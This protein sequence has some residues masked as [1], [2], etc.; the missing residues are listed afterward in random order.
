MGKPPVRFR[1]RLFWIAATSVFGLILSFLAY[2]AYLD[3][4][5]V[6]KFEGV[7]WKIP[8]KIYSIPFQLVP[9]MDIEKVMVLSRLNHLGYYR[10]FHPVR[11]PGEFRRMQDGLE[12]Y[13]RD[14][15]YPGHP[16]SGFPVVLMLEGNTLTRIV[17]LTLAEEIPTIDL[18]PE[19]ISGL[20]EG[21]WQERLLIHLSD[22]S[23]SLIHSVLASE[24]RRFYEHP[25][26]DIRGMLRALFQ[27]LRHGEVVQGGSTLTQQLVKNFYLNS[28]RTLSRKLNE[29]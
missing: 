10:V 25:G 20:Y 19:L 17:D 22:L 14:F 5:I 29:V 26:V 18:E 13:F 11:E 12:I 27:N 6:R 15:P 9:G 4:V 8:S 28:N 3:Q 1:R 16:F 23:P 24:D 21:D 7:R 2:V